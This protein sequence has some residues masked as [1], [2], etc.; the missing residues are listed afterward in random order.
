MRTAF[1]K[2]R[3]AEWGTVLGK[4]EEEKQRSKSAYHLAFISILATK[5]PMQVSFHRKVHCLRA[6]RY[7]ASR[8]RIRT[9]LATKMSRVLSDTDKIHLYDLKNCQRLGLSSN[10]SEEKYFKLFPFFPFN[11]PFAF[12]FIS[13][14]YFPLHLIFVISS[15]LTSHLG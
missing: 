7:R 10:V 14:L 11:F 13:N 3:G 6:A 8:R 4:L 1:H 2:L 15:L 9:F 5:L 12:P